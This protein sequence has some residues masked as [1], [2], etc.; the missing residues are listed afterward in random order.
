MTSQLV[1]YLQEAKAE[2]TKVTWPTKRQTVQSTV[3][4]V[5]ISAAVALFLG[6]IDLG[7][8]KL[9]TIILIG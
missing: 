3:L 2:L 5:V 7:L 8:N 9:L 6:G 4:V 1:S